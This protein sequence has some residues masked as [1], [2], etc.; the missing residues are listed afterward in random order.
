[1]KPENTREP[2]AVVGGQGP[3]ERG[4]RF[5]ATVSVFCRASEPSEIFAATQSIP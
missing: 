5:G 2:E 1:M 3:G 4:I